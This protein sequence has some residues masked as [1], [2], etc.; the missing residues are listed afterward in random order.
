MEL[1]KEIELLKKKKCGIVS[2]VNLEASSPPL[3]S[4]T[5]A[6]SH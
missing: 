4:N 1:L 6:Y 3:P 5:F 2:K